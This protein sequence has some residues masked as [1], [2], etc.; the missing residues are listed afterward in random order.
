MTRLTFDEADDRMPRWHPD[1]SAVTFF[2]GRGGP[3]AM[4]SRRADGT[5]E[6]TVVYRDPRGSVFDAAWA[7]D[8]ASIV[9]RIGGI[10]GVAGARDLYSVRFAED[11]LAQPLLTN[12]GYDE[13]GPAISPDGRWLAYVSDQTGRREVFIRP[14]PDVNSSQVQVSDGGARNVVWDPDGQSVYYITDGPTLGEGRSLMVAELR[15]GPPMAVLRRRALFD[16]PNAFYFANFTTSFDISPDG[17]RF[18]MARAASQDTPDRRRFVLV[19]NWIREVEE[20]IR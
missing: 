18:L 6:A 5:G 15:P 17:E 10:T 7:P 16:I 11:S 13:S 19:K 9:A 14:Y 2:S 1:G 20:R 4:W 3:Y 12:E 8:G